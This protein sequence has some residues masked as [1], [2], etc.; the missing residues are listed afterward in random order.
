MKIVMRDG[1]EREIGPG[2]VASILP[3]H[4]AWED[5]GGYAQHAKQR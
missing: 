3:G 4:E 1:T 2:D 5:F